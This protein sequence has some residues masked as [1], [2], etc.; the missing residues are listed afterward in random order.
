MSL[1]ARAEPSTG[2]FLLPFNMSRAV[3]IRI[4]Y[5]LYIIMIFHICHEYVL[6]IMLTHNNNRLRLISQHY[7]MPSNKVWTYIAV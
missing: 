5:V 7:A 6:V 1:L 4:T 2:R 3:T